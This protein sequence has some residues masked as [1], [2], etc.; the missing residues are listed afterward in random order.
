MATDDAGRAGHGQ[1]SEMIVYMYLVGL[2]KQVSWIASKNM[3][4]LPCGCLS[5]CAICAAELDAV[6]HRSDRGG[7]DCPVCHQRRASG[8]GLR[9]LPETF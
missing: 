2:P 7:K 1:L 8:Q 3:I 4:S 9:A 6:P 5:T